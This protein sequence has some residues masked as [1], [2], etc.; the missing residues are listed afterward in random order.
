[1][2]PEAKIDAILAELTGIMGRLD[3]QDAALVEIREM[4]LSEYAE[5]FAAMPCEGSA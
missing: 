4:L 3:T 1:M 5:D 2:S